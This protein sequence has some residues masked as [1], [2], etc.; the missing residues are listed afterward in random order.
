MFRHLKGTRQ[1]KHKIWIKFYKNKESQLEQL[2]EFIK[3]LDTEG[4]TVFVTHY[5]VILALFS[6]TVTSGEILIANRDLEVIGRIK[7]Y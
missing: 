7:D 5:V 4:N 6:D 2:I 3:N 1:E